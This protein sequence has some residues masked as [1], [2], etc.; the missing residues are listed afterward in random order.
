MKIQLFLIQ[1]LLIFIGFGNF[2]DAKE[3]NLWITDGEFLRNLGIVSGDP[4]GDLAEREFLTRAESATLLCRIN[5]R[6]LTMISL[7]EDNNFVDVAKDAWYAE[8]VDIAYKEGWMKG[9]SKDHFDPDR[10]VDEEMLATVLLRILG[11]E[12]EWGSGKKLAVGVGLRQMNLISMEEQKEAV[13][14]ETVFSYLKKIMFLN[15][16]GVEDLFGASFGIDS[17]YDTLMQG[18]YIDLEEYDQGLQYINSEGEKLV[19]PQISEKENDIISNKGSA[20]EH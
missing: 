8:A 5:K 17:T 19:Y 15:K 20:L 1:I 14:R 16:K 3:A 7:A 18:Y 2:I 13:I 12:P 10:Y 9:M 6:D 11:Y 4:N